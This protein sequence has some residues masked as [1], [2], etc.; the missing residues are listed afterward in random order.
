VDC[1]ILHSALPDRRQMMH[2]WPAMEQ[3]F[4]AGGPRQL[5]ISNCYEAT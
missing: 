5:G 3:I 2:V 1:L 4:R